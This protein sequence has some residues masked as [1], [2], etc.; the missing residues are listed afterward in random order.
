LCPFPVKDI[1]QIFAKYCNCND[2][3][4][5]QEEHENMGAWTFVNARFRNIHNCDLK[6]TGRGPLGTPAVGISSIHKQQ[7]QTLIADAFRKLALHVK[8]ESRCIHVFIVRFGLVPMSTDNE[9]LRVTIGNKIGSGSFGELRRATLSNSNEQL[10]IKLEKKSASDPKLHLEYNIYSFL[11]EQKGIPKV[12]LFGSCGD[13]YAILMQ[14]LGHS[15]DYYHKQ[16]K[17]QFTIETTAKIALQ[18]IDRIECVH[19][20]GVVYRDVK[21]DNFV[22]GTEETDEN[23]LYIIDFGLSKLYV[24]PETKTH[25]KYNED[26]HV[27]GT[28][29]FMSINT[30]YGR[31]QSRRDDLESIGY[32]LIFLLRGKLPWQNLPS[33][34]K[35][36]CRLIGTKKEETTLTEL[37]DGIPEQF[38]TFIS[39]ARDL[40]FE[41]EPD[42]SFLRSLFTEWCTD[43]KFD[44]NI[45]SLVTHAITLN[46]NCYTN[47]IKIITTNAKISDFRPPQNKCHRH[48]QVCLKNVKE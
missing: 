42:Y 18:V 13:F 45:N 15:L 11:G 23:L 46:L 12:K 24:D 5:S 33:K 4:W 7:Q 6:Y 29:R 37:C 48:A 34:S 16:K 41:Q 22:F 44:W 43:D 36:K 8:R 31:E 19:K 3:V 27:V 28:A 40:K 14:L 35:D 38:K 26:R 9:D 21:P 39:Y 1:S 20:K 2:F 30:H 32:M 10:A 47:A 17:R 25:I